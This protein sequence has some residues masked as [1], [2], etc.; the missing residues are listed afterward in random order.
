MPTL[1]DR[2]ISGDLI[3]M[4]KVMSSRQSIDWVKP[5]NLRKNVDISGPAVS[6][7]GNSLSMS[8]ESFSSRERNNFLSWATTRDNFFVNRVVK[9]WNSFL[10]SIVTKKKNQKKLFS[11]INLKQ[12]TATGIHSLV[13]N[14]KLHYNKK[15]I[16]NI[17]KRQFESAF[18]RSQNSVDKAFSRESTAK[19]DI[20]KISTEAIRDLL[21]DIDP[22]KSQGS[23]MVNPYVL[24]EAS[25]E[26]PFLAALFPF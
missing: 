21:N 8:R 23:D 26:F 24:K 10:N 6:V 17:L 2:R 5:L 4:Y 11:Y 1:K 7:R 13:S 9:T 16:A 14:G 15:E 20:I 18:S 12:L 19:L 22:H 3:E 25:V